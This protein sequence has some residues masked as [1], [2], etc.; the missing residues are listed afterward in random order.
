MGV[1]Y[2]LLHE[3]YLKNVKRI[4]IKHCKSIHSIGESNF[5]LNDQIIRVYNKGIPIYGNT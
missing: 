1:T 3:Y 2:K 5:Q 4:Y